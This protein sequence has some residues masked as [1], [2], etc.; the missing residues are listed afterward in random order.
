MI[1]EMSRKMC[2]LRIGKDKKG[3]RVMNMSLKV[4]T[5]K[6]KQAYRARFELFLGPERRYAW[7]SPGAQRRDQ[8]Q[9]A[10]GPWEGPVIH[11]R[12]RSVSAALRVVTVLPFCEASCTALN[13]RALYTARIQKLIFAKSPL[14]LHSLV[15]LHLLWRFKE[16]CSSTTSWN[17]SRQS[18][19]CSYTDLADGLSFWLSQWYNIFVFLSEK[20]KKKKKSRQKQGWDVVSGSCL[21][22]G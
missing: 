20:K 5:L 16:L 9:P 18:F 6:E 7:K 14:S 13:P 2:T 4:F 1:S 15:S 19:P 10:K 11:S 3:K 17:T 12:S 8:K 22:Y 21:L